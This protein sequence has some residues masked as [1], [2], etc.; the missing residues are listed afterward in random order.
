MPVA[1]RN[2]N[3]G[4]IIYIGTELYLGHGRDDFRGGLAEV[5]EVRPDI[6]KGQPTP[7]CASCSRWT[8]S[9]TGSYW[10]QSKRNSGSGTGRSGR[11]PSLIIGQNLMTGSRVSSGSMR[12]ATGSQA[13]RCGGEP[14]S[15]TRGNA[16]RQHTRERKD[17]ISKSAALHF[18]LNLGFLA[19]L[20]ILLDVFEHLIVQLQFHLRIRNRLSSSNFPDALDSKLRPGFFTARMQAPGCCTKQAAE[21][22]EH[23]K[24]PHH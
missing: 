15:T 14:V 3:Q 4:D 18:F 10:L 21:R 19:F 13:L 7:S 16:G 8:R 9:T 1:C 5:S 22:L 12:P 11:I 20:F 17:N 24:T 2:C 6:S 23:L